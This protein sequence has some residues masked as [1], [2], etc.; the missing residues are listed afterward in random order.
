MTSCGRASNQYS[1]GSPVA[2]PGCAPLYSPERRLTPVRWAGAQQLQVV[3][4]QADHVHAGQVRAGTIASLLD[5][6]RQPAGIGS[7]QRLPEWA[8]GD[9]HPVAV[10]DCVHDAALDGDAARTR[11]ACQADGEGEERAGAWPGAS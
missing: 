4:E 8:A 7:A 9:D 5:L 11:L 10:D 3:G 1:A 6:H 2:G